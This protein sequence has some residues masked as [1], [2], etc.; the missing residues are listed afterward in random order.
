MKRMF[1]TSWGAE[2]GEDGTRFRLWAPAQ[3]RLA[4]RCNGADH[5]MDPAAS[6]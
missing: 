5:E 6:G 1:R 4:V 2:L 3:D